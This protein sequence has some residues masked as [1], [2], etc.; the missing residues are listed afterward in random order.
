[1]IYI[2]DDFLD[3]DILEAINKDK[4]NFIE[5]KTP[6]KSFWVK[7]ASK[8]FI[9]IVLDKLS[10]YEG[11]E[12][13]NVLGFFREA[14]I[15]QDD[16]WRIHNDSIINNVRPDRAAVIY[17]SEKDNDVL[18]LTGTA[19]WSHEDHGHAKDLR[20]VND[21]NNVLIEDANDLSKWKLES[22]VGHRK[23]RLVSYPCGY[24]HSKYPNKYIN[25]RVV[26]VIFYKI[27]NKNE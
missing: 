24:F 17:L 12:L 3:N 13:E 26:F 6:N 15:N 7:H 14:K 21:F 27:K 9:N 8:E 19:F 16:D 4:S 18:G 23:N 25:S 22:I 10:H 2:I 1:M 5:H 20:D 11:F